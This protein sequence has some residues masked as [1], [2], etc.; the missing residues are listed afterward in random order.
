VS[1][2]V[3]RARSYVAAGFKK[4]VCG[5]EHVQEVEQCGRVLHVGIVG[6]GMR[7]LWTGTL[8]GMWVCVGEWN[9]KRKMRQKKL[10]NVC[11]QPGELLPCVLNTVTNTR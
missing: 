11:G 3:G 4:R 5:E 1:L 9:N 8:Y 10:C 6:G 7:K 2:G